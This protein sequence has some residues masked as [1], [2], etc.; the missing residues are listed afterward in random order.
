MKLRYWNDKIQNGSELRQLVGKK[1]GD[2]KVPK[3][4]FDAA[5]A[6]DMERYIGKQLQEN[7]VN[8]LRQKINE[9]RGVYV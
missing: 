2:V 7:K 9:L 1:L 3:T 8:K 6:I 5:Q 4:M